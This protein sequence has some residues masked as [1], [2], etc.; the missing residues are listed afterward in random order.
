MKKFLSVFLVLVLLLTCM[1]TGSSKVH[2]SNKADTARV[3]GIVFDNSGSMYTQ[4]NQAWC[5][6]TY[7]M[8]VFASMLNKGDTLLIFPMNPVK[9]DGVEY[10]R[11]TPYKITDAA[12]SIKVREMYTPD[13]GGTPIESIDSSVAYMKEIQSDNKYLIILTDGTEFSQGGK[14][15]K[16]TKQELDKRIQASAGKALTVMYLGMD[17]TDASGKTTEYAV[18]P[19]TPETEYFKKRIAK[20]STDVLSI[21]T[22]MCNQIFGRDTLPANHLLNKKTIDVDMSMNKLIVFVQ[23]QNIANLKISG[24]NGATGQLASTI[25][26]R[27]AENVNGE[28]MDAVS[29]KSLQGMIVTYTDCTAGKFD[30]QYSGTATSIEVYYEPNADLDFVFTDTDGNKVDPNALYEGEYMVSY[31]MKDGRTGELI[32]SDLLGNPRYQGSYSINGKEY[33]ISSEGY[34]GEVKMI[35]SMG[36]TFNAQLTVTYLSGYT[37]SKDA[38]DFGWPKDGIKVAARPAGDL[39]LEI[40]GGD[41]TYP[42]QTLEEGA[43][44]ILK[45]YYQG[46]QLTGDALKSAVPKWDPSN[47]N[48]ELKCDFA[49]DH[50]KITLHYK[51]PAKP[52][53]TPCGEC[54]VPISVA[55]TAPGSD[56]ART[57]GVLVYNIDEDSSFLQAELYAPEDYIVIKELDSTQPMVVTLK[58]NGKSLTAEEFARTQL[59]VD[60]GGIQYTVTPKP[61]SSSYIIQLASTEGIGEGDYPVKVTATYTD[62]IGRT[63]QAEAGTPLTLSHTP[64]WVK[65]LIGIL[66]LILLIILIWIILHIRV[67]PSKARIGAKD[68]KIVVNGDPVKAPQIQG[69]LKKKSMEVVAKMGSAKCGISMAIKPGQESY[70]YKPQKSRYGESIDSK[71]NKIG[72]ARIDSLSIGSARYVRDEA[73]NTLVRKPASKAPIVIKHGT[74]VTYSGIVNSAGTEKPFTVSTKFTFK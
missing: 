34:H 74:N 62:K 54:K 32:S 52:Q 41:G 20:N 71:V 26:T 69:K 42:L 25:S 44:Y 61:E 29:D 11:N 40:S 17:T 10:T 67:L 65:W 59:Q 15:L 57:Q 8:E 2:A 39:R 47:S 53:N 36:D 63:T 66:L 30:I 64:L 22:D 38:T 50:Y 16:N 56:E 58:L 21:L 51:D 13:P 4:G 46:T 35:L 55:Y 33:P 18:E 12:N 73:T 68:T 3:I 19:G 23:G 70:L 7:A 9:V 72:T 37:I 6:A 43:P 28:Y 1:V 14:T 24:Q 48:A 60:C 27:Y 31:G 49:D 5:R 45:L